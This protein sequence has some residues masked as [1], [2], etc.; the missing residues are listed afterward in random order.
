MEKDNLPVKIK[1]PSQK[2]MELALLRSTLQPALNKIFT[3]IDLTTRNKIAERDKEFGTFT[4]ERIVRTLDKAPPISSIALVEPEECHAWLKQM[5]TQFCFDLNFDKTLTPGNI[6]ELVAFVKSKYYFF[7]FS[8]I[9]VMFEMAKRGE[10]WIEEEV[11]GKT[12]RKKLIFYNAITVLMM[13][14]VFKAYDRQRVDLITVNNES[15]VR[16]KGKTTDEN[17]NVFN[18]AKMKYA[19][20]Q[21]QPFKKTKK[22]K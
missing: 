11:Y 17:K 6:E 2:G 4:L 13:Y 16:V 7:T 9:H 14:D 10:L 1:D 21:V 15:Y 12:E 19:M 5:F 8:D 20:E 18:E 3:F 22:K